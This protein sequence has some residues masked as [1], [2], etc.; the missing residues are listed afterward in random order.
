MDVSIVINHYKSPQVLKMALSYVR[1][2]K[3]E[4]EK[5]GGRAEVIVSDSE[6][7]AETKE[8][9]DQLYPDFIFLK[10]PR[11]IG[12]GK[13]VNRALKIVQGE[14]IFI[15]NAD[16]VIPRPEE[17]NKLLNFVKENPEVGIAGPRLLNFDNTHQPSAFRFY[18]PMTILYRRTPLGKLPAG[19][20]AIEDF[21]LQN[22]PQVRERPTEVDWLMGS[23]L[24]TRKDVLDK[25]GFFDERYFMYMEDVDLCRRI[26]EAGYKVM[27]YPYANMY[28]FH[29]KASRNRNIFKALFNKYAR[30]HIQSAWKYFKKF[31]LNTPNYGA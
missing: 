24:L 11:N 2:W 21:E 6:T 4:Y 9:M 18:T 16:F 7:I 5:N 27:Y 17:L 29:G 26:W 8:V 10:E 22:T 15:M 30:I 20:K 23:A 19:K 1:K 13:S 3:E 14:Y 25:V 28:H 31:G 12:F